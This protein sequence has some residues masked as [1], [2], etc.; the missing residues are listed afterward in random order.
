MA[1]NLT[2]FFTEYF[3]S[4]EVDGI[5]SSC[6]QPSSYEDSSS[7][8]YVTEEKDISN[9]CSPMRDLNNR[10]DNFDI[11]K[12]FNAMS[13]EKVIEDHKVFRRKVLTGGGSECIANNCL[14]WI[15][16]AT[17]ENMI[18]F[19]AEKRASNDQI[20]SVAAAMFLRMEKYT[21]MTGET[22]EIAKRKGD[23]IHYQKKFQPIIQRSVM[24]QDYFERMSHWPSLE[25]VAK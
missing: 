17:M 21:V 13:E 25:F 18:A 15:Y 6:T 5:L 9:M 8:G 14:G 16:A 22:I 24:Y 3:E 2:F 1:I 23:L 12:V 10:R 19:Q 20:I 4:N 7:R 11:V